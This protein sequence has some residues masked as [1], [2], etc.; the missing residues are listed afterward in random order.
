MQFDLLGKAV[1]RFRLPVVDYSSA[2]IV[3]VPAQQGDVNTRFFE[4]TLYDDRGDIDLSTYSQAML[5]GTTPDGRTLSSNSCEISD[6][7]KTVVVNFGGE[8]AAKAGRVT[9]DILFTDKDK[10]IALTSKT[11]YVF[12]SESRSSNILDESDD[13]YN[14]LLRLLRDVA[15]LENDV[16]TAETSRVAAEI[17]RVNAEASRVSTESARMEAE[18]E[19][20]DAETARKSAEASRA[21]SENIRVNA[22]VERKEAEIARKSAETSRV[23]VECNRVEAEAVRNEAETA[24]LTDEGI[25]RQNESGRVTA[26]NA[27]V[28]AEEKREADF[29]AAKS[30]CITATQGA[31]EAADN[32]R[33]LL[34]ALP[35]PTNVV[36][37]NTATPIMEL[38]FI[39]M[40]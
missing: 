35:C 33:V 5:C 28:V 2:P 9:C 34:E 29:A 18:T 37:G 27:R 1:R 15:K 20:E 16:E 6:D 4:V 8:F 30:E 25:R 3:I 26:E 17:G 40:E 7:H 19:R 11:F 31:D 39:E 10:T 13:E 38:L 32:V 14:Q 12:V 36:S 24:R 22:E 23:E 21:N